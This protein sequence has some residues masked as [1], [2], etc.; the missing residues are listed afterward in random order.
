MAIH[1]EARIPPFC[2][3]LPGLSTGSVRR[4]RFRD[5][6]CH[7]QHECQWPSV[8][9]PT[10]HPEGLLSQFHGHGAKRELGPIA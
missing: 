6:R 2:A 7:E 3:S 1:E 8:G 9:T 5:S 4:T 10:Q